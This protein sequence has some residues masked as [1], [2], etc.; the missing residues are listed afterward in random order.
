MI[1]NAQ[2][3]RIIKISENATTVTYTV[4]SIKEE[5]NS[6]AYVS[7]IKLATTTFSPLETHFSIK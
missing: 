4:E 3:M 6:L 1:E 2:S 7:S 5:R